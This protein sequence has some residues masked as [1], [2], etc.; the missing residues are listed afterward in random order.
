MARFAGTRAPQ[1]QGIYRSAEVKPP[2]VQGLK[3]AGVTTGAG[4]AANAVSVGSIKK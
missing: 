4:S 2:K 3:S 1:I